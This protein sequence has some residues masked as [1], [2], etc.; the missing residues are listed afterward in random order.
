MDDLLGMS[1]NKCVAKL[2]GVFEKQEKRI[3]R[4]M[5]IFVCNRLETISN[6]ILH[7]DEN[8]ALFCLVDVIYLG[9]IWMLKFC[10][11]ACFVQ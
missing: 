3:V 6:D 4:Q 1:G 9:N 5:M 8:I 10:A 2:K 7:H 11:Q